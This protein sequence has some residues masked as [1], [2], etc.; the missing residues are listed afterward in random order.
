M[1]RTPSVTLT[2][3]QIMDALN[4]YAHIGVIDYVA[5]STPPGEQWSIGVGGEPQTLNGDHEATLWLAGLSAGLDWA[6]T[7]L[8]QAGLVPNGAMGQTSPSYPAQ[9]AQRLHDRHRAEDHAASPRPDDC[10][11]CQAGAS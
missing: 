3:D 9:L 1:T 10:P 6:R 5:M 11:W 4:K 7:F 8:V 2:T